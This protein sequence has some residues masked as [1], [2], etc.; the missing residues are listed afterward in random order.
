MAPAQAI[1]VAQLLP[2]RTDP[3]DSF[4]GNVVKEITRDVDKSLHSKSSS[5]I[6][7]KMKC[8]KDLVQHLGNGFNTFW[9]VHV[10]DH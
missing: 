7:Y 3:S 9:Y 2:A 10:T 5:G 4:T 1:P 6:I 8:W